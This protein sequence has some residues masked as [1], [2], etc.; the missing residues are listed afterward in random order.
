MELFTEQVAANAPEVALEQLGECRALDEGLER[1]DTFE[2]TPAVHPAM[3]P[4]ERPTQQPHLYR[5]TPQGCILSSLPARGAVLPDT[6]ACRLPPRS[7]RHELARPSF[8]AA[9]AFARP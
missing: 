3:A 4:G 1:L 2:N 7:G 9:T 6:A 8:S 5:M